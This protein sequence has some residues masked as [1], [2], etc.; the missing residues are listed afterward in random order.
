MSDR[1]HQSL[2]DESIQSLRTGL[3]FCEYNGIISSHNRVTGPP[4]R[5]QP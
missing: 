5:E 3:P 4:V 1:D 2:H